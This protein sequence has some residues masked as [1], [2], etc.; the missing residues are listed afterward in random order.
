MLHMVKKH[1]PT[2]TTIEET[3]LAGITQT[4]LKHVQCIYTHFKS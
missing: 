3:Q 2:T 1:R 4:S